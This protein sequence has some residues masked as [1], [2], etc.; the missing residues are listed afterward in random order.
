MPLHWLRSIGPAAGLATGL[1]LGTV[2]MPAHAAD[3][4]TTPRCQ[5]PEE[6]ATAQ[7]AIAQQCDCA[8]ATK[9]S[10][11]MKCVKRVVNQALGAKSL[12]RTCKGAVIQCE[13]KIGC[14][15]GIRPLRTVQQI[16]TQSCALSSCHSS[17]T[18]Q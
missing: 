17:I 15:R 2:A 10:A 7:L 8:G 3:D 14:G 4:C 9:A 1:L 6:I 13:A 18:R 11:Y 5:N 16:F 12:A